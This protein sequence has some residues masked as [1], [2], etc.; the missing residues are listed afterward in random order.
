VSANIALYGMMGAGKST[1][2]QRL[3]DR[4]GRRAVDT[5]DE[6]VRWRD[7]SIP[8]IFAAEGEQAFRS[9][10]S[11]VIRELAVHTDLVLALGGG[12]VLSDDN[13]ADL[14]L[15]SVLVELR[16]TADTLAARLAHETDERPLLAGNDDLRASID[17]MI[18]ERSDRYAQVAD[19]TVDADQAPDDVV[20]QILDWA[21]EHP[22]ILTPSEF[23]VVM[24]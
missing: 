12:A 14:A 18:A 16:A 8:L 22:D 6:I 2:A 9:Y 10:E 24:Q 13:V 19:L 23:E 21:R 5:D 7:T 15:T 4:L 20:E 3:A 17:Q 1:V 11:T